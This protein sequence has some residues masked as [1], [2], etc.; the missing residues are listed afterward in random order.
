MT[1]RRHAVVA[2]ATL[3]TGAASHA[4]PP[5]YRADPVPAP[6]LQ[7]WPGVPDSLAR[8]RGVALSSSGLVLG[9]VDCG[10]TIG[11]SRA[12]VVDAAG[13]VAEL[14]SGS[15]DF[16]EPIAFLGAGRVLVSG[17]WCPPVNGACTTA[18]SIAASDGTLSILGG[19]PSGV[20][21]VHSSNEQG[22][23]VGS[24]AMVRSGAFRLRPDGTVDDLGLASSLSA[25]WDV[26]AKCVLPDG[27]ALGSARLAAGTRAVRWSPGGEATVLEHPSGAADSRA[28]GG[29]VD[30]TAVGAVD[31][32]AVAW[33]PGGGVLPLMPAGSDS[34]GTHVGGNLL[35]QGPLGASIFGTHR[36]G[37]RLFRASAFGPGSDL[38]PSIAQPVH[39]VEVVSAPRADLMVAR[40]LVGLYEPRSYLWRPAIGLVD[41]ETVVVDRPAGAAPLQVVAANAA[42]AILVNDGSTLEPRLLR[43]LRDGDVGGDGRVD[44]AD[45]GALLSRWG[46]VPPGTRSAADM[47][48]NG[49]VDGADLGSLL[50]NWG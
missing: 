10:T 48:G 21:A 15:F 3:A 5:R 6:A 44:G 20:S 50:S 33:L 38:G 41:L 2:L 34:V 36:S 19:S 31:G 29:S 16:V 26:E 46:P 24:G 4:L 25:A 49:R 23:A 8:G 9:E 14:P 43:E 17:D 18:L 11:G 42:G 27:R 12:Y 37:T 7:C 28:A 39:L 32:V 45:I 1:P 35:T 30:G 47:D 40:A 22:W 13:S